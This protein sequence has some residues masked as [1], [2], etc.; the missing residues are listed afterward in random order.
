MSVQ[1]VRSQP[2][3]KEYTDPIT[4]HQVSKQPHD[5]MLLSVLVLLF[6]MMWPTIF[7]AVLSVIYSFQVSTSE[8]LY[9][10]YYQTLYYITTKNSKLV[11]TIQN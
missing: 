2:D 11:V 9:Y 6:C 8:Y 4:G 3:P 1:V 5:H 7:C 10:L